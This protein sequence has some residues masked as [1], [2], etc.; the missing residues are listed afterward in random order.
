MILHVGEQAKDA[1]RLGVAGR[2]EGYAGTECVTNLA[3]FA[4]LNAS[5]HKADP[6]YFLG[7]EAAEVENDGLA[8]FDLMVA[9]AA[10]QAQ[11]G[12][13]S[14]A[15]ASLEFVI[16]VRAA[17]RSYTDSVVIISVSVCPQAGVGRVRR[18]VGW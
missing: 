7:K 5:Q 10:G 1:D 4:T 9:V 18:T 6:G 15:D 8:G 11:T 2:A 13:S 17:C 12:F 16:E 14:A 3:A